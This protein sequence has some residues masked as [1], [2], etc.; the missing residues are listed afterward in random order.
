MDKI[1]RKP[2]WYWYEYWK[3]V[4]IKEAKKKLEKI[5]SDEHEEYLAHL[6][7]KYIMDSK[8][9]EDAGYDKGLNQGINQG[10]NQGKINEK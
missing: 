3:N 6:R 4:A 9:I 7:Q 10:I 1:Y 2:R 8:A 5:S